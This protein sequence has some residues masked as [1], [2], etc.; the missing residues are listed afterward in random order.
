MFWFSGYFG[1]EFTRNSDAKSKDEN[2]PLPKEIIFLLIVCKGIHLLAL[3]NLFVYKIVS[4]IMRY[5]DNKYFDV[6][7]HS[8]FVS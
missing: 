7:M 2:L 1:E 5:F 4:T 3:Y 8:L 6:K